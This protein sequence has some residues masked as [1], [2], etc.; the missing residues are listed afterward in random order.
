MSSIGRSFDTEAQHLDNPLCKKEDDMIQLVI[1]NIEYIS[2][3][4]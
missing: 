1:P 2:G 3:F 4:K